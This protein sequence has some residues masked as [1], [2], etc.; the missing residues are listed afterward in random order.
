MLPACVQDAILLAWHHA[1]LFSYRMLWHD[2]MPMPLTWKL[3]LQDRSSCAGAR[4][5]LF[6]W[7]LRMQGCIW[8]PDWLRWQLSWP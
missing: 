6:L 7:A 5:P 4:L 3:L 1:A 2:I 8:Q